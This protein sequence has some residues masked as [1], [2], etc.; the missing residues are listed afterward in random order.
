MLESIK[1]PQDLHGLSY[2][3]L[4]ELSSEIRQFLITKVSKTGGHLGPNLG[5]V[6]LTLAIHRTF[7]SPKDVVLFDTGHQSYVHKM[8]TG[9]AEQ[10]DGL[11]QRG[12]IAGYPNRRES[13]HDVIENSHASTALSWADGISL[14]F[15]LTN[16]RDRHVVV[17]V[18]DGAL[19]GGMSW[20]ALNNIATSNDRNLTIV[21]NDNERSY[22]PTIGGLATYLA[23]LRVTRGYERFL[24]WGK[25]ILSHTPVVGA[26]IYETLH[27]MKKG[28]KDIV[29][30]QGMFED[31]GLK[32]VGPIDGHNIEAMERALEQ[33]K[34]FGE[35]VLIHVITEKGKGHQPAVADEAEKFHAVGVVDPETGT[36]LAKSSTSWTN[37]F[38]EELLAL[39]KERKDI[40][41]ITAAMLGPTG[42]DKFQS[43]FPERTIDVGIAE[44]HAVTS[45]AGLAF[46]GLHPVIAVYSTFLN[47]AFDQLLLDVA[48]HKAGVTFVLDRAGITGDDG[49]SHHGIW[50]L[51]ITGLVPTMHVAAPRDAAR[52]RETLREAVAIN[53]APT[54]VRFPKGAVQSDIPAFER[55]D[56]VD[57]L[58]RGESAD[59]LL[60]SIGSMA[61][62]AVEA[63]SQ[64][65]REGV[66]V[67]VIDP[68]WVKPLPA[69][70][71]SMADRYKSI[72]VL[73]DGI[74]H[75]GI[76]SAISEQCRE[77]GLNI[78]IH[79]IGVPLEFIEHSSRSEIL[80]DLGITAQ[81]ISRDIVEWNST[82]EEMQFPER[83]NA[84][85][86]PIR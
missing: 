78:A 6:E 19:T 25:E 61:A 17:V 33:A 59:V 15:S 62:I 49:P 68:R 4:E 51:A 28:I 69:S 45:A 44:Q 47:R 56:G 36:P 11:R 63:A 71:I 37:I 27:G 85:R 7:D 83:E 46:A 67:T 35:P 22:S 50:D 12:G 23:T 42:L 10:F 8:I 43:E 34:E 29:A 80:E 26:P 73:E 81:K 40:V 30:P 64:A 32:Y 18:G 66:G 41:A 75:G 79:S 65:Y 86:K 60:I 53:D 20:E 52:L 2:E 74:K 1:S 76:A 57:V 5:V 3:Q 13:E 16:Q 9:R 70:L 72:V 38:S 84:D 77:A 31:L 48:L 14:G 54:A 55:R 21:V 82:V 24:D 58:Y 39:G